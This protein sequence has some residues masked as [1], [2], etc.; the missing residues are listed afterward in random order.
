MIF[1]FSP[2]PGPC[3]ACCLIS[4]RLDVPGPGCFQGRPRAV[5]NTADCWLS[6]PNH[7][8]PVHSICSLA[9][10]ASKLHLT[11]PDPSRSEGK[12]YFPWCQCNLPRSYESS[13]GH[14]GSCS[15][16]PI[17]GGHLS[18][19][20]CWPWRRCRRTGDWKAGDQGRPGDVV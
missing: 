6:E 5:Q 3:W 18:I 8:A 2:Q 13:Q 12:A 11:S 20:V 14:A 17:L 15:P 4:V 7:V 19:R 9:L 1:S 10:S 16:K